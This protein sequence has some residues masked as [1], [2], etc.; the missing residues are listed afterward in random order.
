ML[1]NHKNITPITVI[2]LSSELGNLKKNSRRGEAGIFFEAN[3]EFRGLVNPCY[4]HSPASNNDKDPYGVKCHIRAQCVGGGG[5][6][7][8]KE[9]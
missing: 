2:L 5:N 3:P 7:I 8:G 4:M 1:G 6:M 9:M